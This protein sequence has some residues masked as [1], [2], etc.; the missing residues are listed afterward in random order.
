MEGQ[1]VLPFTTWPHPA[2][3]NTEIKGLLTIPKQL[4]VAKNYVYHPF[5]SC[6]LLT[7]GSLDRRIVHENEVNE[8]IVLF[9]SLIKHIN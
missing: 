1:A 2:A 5:K 6:P 9:K 8:F 3:L 4:L 7:E